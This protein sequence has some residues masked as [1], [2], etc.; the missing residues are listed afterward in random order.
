MMP[1]RSLRRFSSPIPL[2]QQWRY[3][4]EVRLDHLQSIREVAVLIA[5]DTDQPNEILSRPVV[6][7]ACG[8]GRVAQVF[9]GAAAWSA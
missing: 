9:G 6:G 4:D 2:R 8:R 5:R 1:R 3:V 7:V